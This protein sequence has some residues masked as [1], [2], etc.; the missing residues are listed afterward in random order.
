MNNTITLSQ[1]ITQLAKATGVDNNTARKFIR[2]L[3]STIEETLEEGQSISINHLGTFRRGDTDQFSRR[4]VVVFIPD[5]AVSDELNRPFEMFEPV[6]LAEGV[7]FDEPKE[8]PQPEVNAP[9]PQ[10][11]V[12]VKETVKEPEPIVVSAPEPV[13]EE[14]VIKEPV[15]KEE[16]VKEK[17]R[18]FIT[19]RISIPLGDAGDDDDI[20]ATPRQSKPAK[21]RFPLWAWALI[22]FAIAAVVGYALAVY[23]VPVEPVH[24]EIA[25][26]EPAD[27]DA[28]QVEEVS[29]EDLASQSAATS[30]PQPSTVT[31]APSAAPQVKASEPVYDTVEISLIRLARKHYG[32]NEFWVYIFDANSD[33]IANPNK[34]RPGTRVVIPDRSTIPGATPQEAKALAKRRQSEILSQYPDRFATA[35]QFCV[36]AL[37]AFSIRGSIGAKC[38]PSVLSKTTVAP[39]L[40]S[41]S[42]TACV[43]S[44]MPL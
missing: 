43:S 44:T 4:G 26:E 2:T 20:P 16:P 15:I 12:I 25:A 6:E 22:F 1:L 33:K 19:E 40:R 10:P 30:S 24:T 11:E 34:I 42:T 38:D 41:V 35:G 3:F 29:V 21:K 36:K 18:E 27:N 8:D 17:P 32:V 14:P 13:V 28:V 23:L 9:E 39:S 5:K 7:V 31:E 37:R